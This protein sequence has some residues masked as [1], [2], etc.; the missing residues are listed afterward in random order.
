MFV[1]SYVLNSDG[2]IPLN[3]TNGGYYPVQNSN[4]W[5][6]DLTLC[7]VA[8]SV[9]QYHQFETEQDLETYLADVGKD[10]KNPDG[11]PFDPVWNAN[12]LWSQSL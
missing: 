8:S 11:T 7:G 2:T 5:P 3:V 1:I 10:W 12:W 6:Q 9:E 4:P